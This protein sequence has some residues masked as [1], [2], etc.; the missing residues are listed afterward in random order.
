MSIFKLKRKG[1]L[2]PVGFKVYFGD[3][4]YLHA[5]DEPDLL[6][7]RDPNAYGTPWIPVHERSEGVFEPIGYEMMGPDVSDTVLLEDPYTSAPKNAYRLVA[8]LPERARA[9][10][11]DEHGDWHP[12][13]LMPVLY[14]GYSIDM[15]VLSVGVRGILRFRHPERIHTK[16]CDGLGVLKKWQG[17]RRRYGG[18]RSIV[19]D[20][21]LPWYLEVWEEVRTWPTSARSVLRAAGTFFSRLGSAPNG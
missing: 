2:V 14:R 5:L 3:H 1:A 6:L 12:T 13:E 4:D 18:S 8:P 7:V 16:T 9:M 17:R 19:S 10:V 20:I 15:P 21:R 11:L